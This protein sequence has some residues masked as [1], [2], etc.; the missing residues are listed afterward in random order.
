MF[1]P[2]SGVEMNSCHLIGYRGK[3]F[4]EDFRLENE[5]N[6]YQMINEPSKFC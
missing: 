4:R 1:D 6:Q 2:I 5:A 3:V